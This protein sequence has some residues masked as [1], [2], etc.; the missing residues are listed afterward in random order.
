MLWHISVKSADIRISMAHLIIMGLLQKWRTDHYWSTYAFSNI[1]F[2][3]K[4]MSCN[5]FQTILQNPHLS[6]NT[7]NLPPTCLSWTWTCT[8]SKKYC[9]H[10]SRQL[11]AYVQTWYGSV[12]VWIQLSIQ[13]PGPICY[14]A[15]KKTA[16]LLIICLAILYPIMCNNLHLQIIIYLCFLIKVPHEA[17]YDQWSSQWLHLQL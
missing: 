16:I 10:G 4:Y 1:P 3:G 8:Q 17:I 5:H 9:K 15:S 13:R 6:E 12:L 7:R 2:F 14:N 11:H